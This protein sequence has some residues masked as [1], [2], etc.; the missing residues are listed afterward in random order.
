MCLT[1]SKAVRREVCSVSLSVSE[2]VSEPRRLPVGTQF[3]NSPSP[4]GYYMMASH[5][6]YDTCQ[7]HRHASRFS[8]GL[9]TPAE[10]C[11][12]YY[13]FIDHWV[14]LSNKN[15][16]NIGWTLRENPVF[17]NASTNPVIP[18]YAFNTISISP[19]TA[20]GDPMLGVGAGTRKSLFYMHFVQL[21]K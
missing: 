12:R 21:R 6:E 19:T 10:C 20:V 13:Q 18:E 14:I 11:K 16:I 2:T 8:H 5:W 17:R 9:L 1:G 4:N 3:H 7:V 15:E